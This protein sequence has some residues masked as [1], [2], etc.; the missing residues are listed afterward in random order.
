M[1]GVKCVVIGDGLNIYY[2][3]NYAE[4]VEIKG[5][6]MNKRIRPIIKCRIC[7]KLKI[8]GGI[9]LCTSCYQKENK[10]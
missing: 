8:H 4:V 10:K 6:K 7:K 3:I 9:G 2:Q 5:V 1:L